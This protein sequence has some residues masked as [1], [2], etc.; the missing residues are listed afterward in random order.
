ME[1]LCLGAVFL[2]SNGN[3]V[4][5]IPGSTVKIVWFFT[6]DISSLIFRSWIF[7]PSDGRPLV[8]LARIVDDGD[9]HVLTS[10][11]EVAVEKPATLVLKNVN[12]T[13]NGTYEFSLSAVSVGTSEVVVYIA[14][15]LSIIFFNWIL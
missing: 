7:T 4:T 2:A 9:V 12:V 8:R 13:Y 14:G 10:S 15:K 1:Y 11:Y 5:F 3:N 6:D